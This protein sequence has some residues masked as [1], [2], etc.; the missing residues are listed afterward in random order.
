MARRLKLTLPKRV[1]TRREQREMLQQYGVL[2]PT[3]SQILPQGNPNGSQNGTQD[4]QI[5]PT[6]KPEQQSP[7]AS[8]A[9]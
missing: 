9:G 7:P 1:T 4:G 5:P 8:Q 6:E 3:R 2:I